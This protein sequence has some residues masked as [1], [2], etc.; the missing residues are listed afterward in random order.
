MPDTIHAALEDL[1]R[2]LDRLQPAVNHIEA[3]Q[4]V[5]EAVERLPDLQERFVTDLK[6][7]H[8]EQID[9][10]SQRL[11][12]LADESQ[13]SYQQMVEKLRGHSDNLA[14]SSKSLQDKLG[15]DSQKLHDDLATKIGKLQD[16][17]RTEYAATRG[18]IDKEVQKL[19]ELQHTIA[20]YYDR[21]AKIDFPTRLEKLDATVAGIMSATQTTQ[22]RVDKLETRMAENRKQLEERITSEIHKLDAP[23]ATMKTFLVI[24]LVGL[25]AAIGLLLFVALT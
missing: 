8:S 20:D 1:R 9:A 19:S 25:V 23:L 2:E 4:R 15:Q 12:E 10:G 21:I 11:K 24:A 22:Q 13:K 5:T 6:R 17:F 3:A 14:E 16:D 18:E 7:E